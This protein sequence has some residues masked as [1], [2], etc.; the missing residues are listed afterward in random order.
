MNS[1]VPDGIHASVRDL[2]AA[3]AFEQLSG[4]T[5]RAARTFTGADG[6][7]F[8]LRQGGYCYYAD[9][10]AIAPL[11]K[12]RR[13]PLG[14][15]ISGWVMTHAEAVAIPDVFD[16]PRIP[17]EAYRPTFVRSMVMV[18]VYKNAPIAALG[19]YW[20]NS[21]V[22]APFHVRVLELLAEAVAVSLTT[23]RPLDS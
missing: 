21:H 19:A 20:A 8:V 9:E 5:R 22:A 18:P 4:L 1:P 2:C 13:F 11:W 23:Q 6:V 10:D 16:D 15:C 7:T 12:G 17:H 3:R 14:T